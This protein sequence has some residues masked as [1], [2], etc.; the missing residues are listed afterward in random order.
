MHD[1]YMLVASVAAASDAAASIQIIRRG[2]L[3]KIDLEIVADI[4]ADLENVMVEVSRQNAWQGQT[5]N[6]QGILASLSLFGNLT[7]SGA[8]M[9]R[10]SQSFDVDVNVVP[11]DF[12]YLN[13]GAAIVGVG[14]VPGAVLARAHL[15]VLV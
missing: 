8:L 7:T 13:F 15:Q 12:I 14:A 1:R 4:D 5:N 6:A 11:L 9:S 3:Q 10:A 2:T